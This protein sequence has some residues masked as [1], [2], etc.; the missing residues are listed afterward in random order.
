MNNRIFRLATSFSGWLL[1]F[2]NRT[3]GELVSGGRKRSYLLYVPESYDPGTPT[4]LVISLHGFAEWP[5]HQMRISKWNELANQ[6]GFMVAYPCGT[7]VPL[8]WHT[9]AMPGRNIDTQDEVTFISDL[10]DQLGDEYNLDPTRVYV[11][12][13]SNGGGMAFVLGCRLPER[14]AAV[15]AVAGYFPFSWDEFHPSRPVPTMVFHGTS[16]PIVPYLGGI[17]PSS[18]IRMPSIPDWAGMLARH[19]GCEDEPVELPPVG[20][21]SGFHYRSKA[22]HGDVIFYRI[23]GGGHSWPGGGSLPKIIVGDTNRD[24]HATDLMWD[25]FR[26]HALEG[27]E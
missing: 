9:Y 11:N 21:V 7:R 15:G 26:E 16:D 27:G 3:N 18:S 12:G 10:I 22:G 8:R 4:P 24:I 5:A 14:I 23:E 20:A 2:V 1:P 19:N 17:R 25:F 13:L 6:H